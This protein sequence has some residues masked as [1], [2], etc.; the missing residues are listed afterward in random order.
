MLPTY[1]AFNSTSFKPLPT[2]FIQLDWDT[3]ERTCSHTWAH[4]KW[5]DQED[6]SSNGHRSEE[7]MLEALMGEQLRAT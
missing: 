7:G 1:P 4:L 6:D 5:S 3:G 2:A